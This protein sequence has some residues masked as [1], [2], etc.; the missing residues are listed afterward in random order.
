M[1]TKLKFVLITFAV[2]F[3]TTGAAV[4]LLAN[5]WPQVSQFK[6]FFHQIF[7]IHLFCW[8]ILG[9]G[10]NY[11]WDLFREN[12]SWESFQ[13][14]RLILPLLVGPIVFYPTWSL[15]LASN[16][17]SHITFELI[18]F[19]NGFFWQALFAKAGPVTS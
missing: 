5:D 17:E 14:P 1:N 7:V 9:M 18:A 6:T 11:F 16:G 2:L 19:Q 8:M 3:V 4:S 12:K 10:A 13:L 15:W